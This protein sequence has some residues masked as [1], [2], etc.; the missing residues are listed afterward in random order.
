MSTFD[1]VWTSCETRCCQKAAGFDLPRSGRIRTRVIDYAASQVSAMEVRTR[2]T[3]WCAGDSNA[4]MRLVEVQ[5]QRKPESS[6]KTGII[7]RHAV[8]KKSV[9]YATLP[10]NRVGGASEAFQSRPDCAGK[11]SQNPFSPK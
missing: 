3:L 4:D 1:V 8:D 9:F 5:Q 7:N 11:Q 6:P 2:P 10:P